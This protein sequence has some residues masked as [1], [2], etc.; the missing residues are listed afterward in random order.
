MHRI[1]RKLSVSLPPFIWLA[2]RIGL[3]I[4]LVA[5]YYALL[6]LVGGGFVWVAHRFWLRKDAVGFIMNYVCQFI[7]I[8][9]LV[10]APV[11]RRFRIPGARLDPVEHPL[12][13]DRVRRIASLAGQDMPAEIYATESAWTATQYRGGILCFGGKPVLLIGL[14]LLHLLTVS[15]FDAVVAR[16]FGHIRRRDPFT[17]HCIWKINEGIRCLRYM[18]AG[19]PL[20]LFWKRTDIFFFPFFLYQNFLAWLLGPICQAQQLV[21]DRYAAG[22][23]GNR[24]LADALIILE[25]NTGRFLKYRLHEVLPAA[26]LGYEIPLIDGF[27]AYLESSTDPPDEGGGDAQPPLAERLSAIADLAV[28]DTND[29]SPALSLV[30][31]LESLER[32]ALATCAVPGERKLKPI[33]WLEAGERVVVTK[34]ARMSWSNHAAYGDYSLDCLPSIV[35]FRLDAFA[36]AVWER[37]IR[38]AAE[39]DY[40]KEVLIAAFG[41]HLYREGWDI[42]HKPGSTRMSRDGA[43]IDPNQLIK[44]MASPEFT[45]DKWRAMLATWKL[46]PFSYL[47]PHR[48]SGR[49]A[50]ST[51]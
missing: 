15:Q 50:A 28:G 33:P 5:G 41:Y 17:A 11:P 2:V 19:T 40:A 3:S 10:S 1:A 36:K 46:D 29:D 6:I 14:P 32:G 34:W 26:L 35:A 37:K 24:A 30:N 47:D 48:P 12:L 25:E 4:A 16:E 43:T 45:Q 9:I 13:F 18:L 51:S 49:D 20:T 39:R 44:D 7:G 31:H 38:D 21:A 42:D 8:P 22:L 27:A 23:V